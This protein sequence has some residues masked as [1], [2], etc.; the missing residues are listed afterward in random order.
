MNN[1]YIIHTKLLYRLDMTRELIAIYLLS[2]TG[3]MSRLYL[4]I[5]YTSC[6][7]AEVEEKTINLERR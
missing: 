3:W 1:V 5:Q 2:P 6:G 7:V 4:H